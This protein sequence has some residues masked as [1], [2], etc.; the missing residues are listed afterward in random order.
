MIRVLKLSCYFF[1]SKSTFGSFQQPHDNGLITD[2]QIPMSNIDEVSV[3]IDGRNSESEPPSSAEEIH[4]NPV[5]NGK[6]IF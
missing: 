1:N 2:D 6:Q 5:V 3:S 4:I